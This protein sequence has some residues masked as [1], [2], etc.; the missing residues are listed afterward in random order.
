MSGYIYYIKNTITGK[1]YIGQ[2]TNINRRQERHF[3]DLRAGNHHSIKLQ[4]AYDKYGAEAFELSWDIYEV[5]DETELLLLEQ[6]KIQE[7]NSFHDGYNMTPGGEGS[8]LAFDFETARALYDILQR[9]SGVNRQIAR[10]FHCDHS[11][12]DDLKNNTIYEHTPVNK[13]RVHELI[14]LIGL[15]DENLNENYVKHNERKLTR[16]ICFELLSIIQDESGY[17]RLLAD[18]YQVDSKLLYRLKRGQIYKEYIDEYNTLD[19]EAKKALKESVKSK[20][21]LEHLRLLRKR[22]NVKTPLTQDQVNYI[23]DNKDTK[24]R[25]EIAE[26]LGISSDRVSS[27]VNNKSYKD[28]IANYHSSKQ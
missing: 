22:G 13:V 16:E 10:F 19:I 8:H 1:M 27:V 26:D 28:L 21:D 3:C 25:V 7:Y 15:C 4:R 12:I 18:L 11:V 5:A 14:T 24:K 2:T 6:Q 23:L 17:D 9:Y 20:H